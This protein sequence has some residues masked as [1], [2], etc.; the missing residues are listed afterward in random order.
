MFFDDQSMTPEAM[1]DMEPEPKGEL[2]IMDGLR[3]MSMFKK[4]PGPLKPPDLN[5]EIKFALSEN[6]ACIAQLFY[7]GFLC[8]SLVRELEQMMI[9]NQPDMMEM[10][11]MVEPG[12]IIMAKGVIMDET[13]APKKKKKKR[14]IPTNPKLYA[15]VKA[16]AKRKFDVYPSA[17]ANAWL[18]RTYKKRGGGY[19]K[20]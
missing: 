11:R 13:G 9:D 18:V 19:R 15:R 16:E 1:F 20:G 14:N 3:A 4:D 10:P 7:E 5:Q 17:Y 8:E 2:D 6:P 12:V